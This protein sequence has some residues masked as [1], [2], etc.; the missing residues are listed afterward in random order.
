VRYE[1]SFTNPD[2][3]GL[4]GY[5]Y[6]RVLKFSLSGDLLTVLGGQSANTFSSDRDSIFAM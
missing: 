2:V 4:I 1:K 5:G 3:V 6:L